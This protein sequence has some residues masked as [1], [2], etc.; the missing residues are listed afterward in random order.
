MAKRWIWMSMILGSLLLWIKPRHLI[1]LTLVL[2]LGTE[3]LTPELWE[4]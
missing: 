1:A 4:S 2:L 3:L